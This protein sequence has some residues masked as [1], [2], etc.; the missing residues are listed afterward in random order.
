MIDVVYPSYIKKFFLVHFLSSH[1]QNQDLIAENTSDEALKQ[2][3]TD[4]TAA[5]TAEATKLDTAKEH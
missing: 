1:D 3:V 2:K 4:T 5:A